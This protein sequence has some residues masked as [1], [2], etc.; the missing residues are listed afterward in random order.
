MT[1]LP[2]PD[3]FVYSL[4]Y[5]L[6][7]YND[8]HMDI[9]ERTKIAMTASRRIDL[10]ALRA[11]AMLLGIALHASL[12][13]FPFPWL[14]HDHQR[15][16]LLLLFLAI[17]HGF[18]MPL[19]FILSGYFTML[20]Y[21]RSGI[22]KLLDQRFKRIFLP[23]CVALLSII[24]LSQSFE[25]SKARTVKLEPD[26]EGII[27]GTD[28]ALKACVR[29]QDG[30]IWQDP[31]WK[32]SALAW[33][34]LLGKPESVK[35]LMD[36]GA[37]I[38][39]QDQ[40]GNTLLHFA[41]IFGRAQEAE[42]LIAGGADPLARNKLGMVPAHGL[43]T[44][45]TQMGEFA[46]QIG[47]N[48]IRMEEIR[49][50]RQRLSNLLPLDNTSVGIIDQLAI[51]SSQWQSS[52]SWRINL[53]SWS[54]HLF[55]SNVFF[56]LWFLWYLCWMVLLFAAL[57]R[58]SLLPSTRSRPRLVVASLF[59]QLVMGTFLTPGFG[60]DTSVGLLPKL[61]V[62]CY[63]A[64][65]FFYGCASFD[66]NSLE[67]TTALKRWK[68]LFVIAFIFFVIGLATKNNRI[69]ATIFQPAYAWTMS[70][71]LIGFFSYVASR[72]QWL[73]SSPIVSWL[74]DAS[75]WMYLVHVPLVIFLQIVVRRFT[76]PAELKFLMVMV[77]AT[78]VL[79]LSYRWCVRYTWIGW[80]LNGPRCF[81]KAGD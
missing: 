5:R 20:V 69:L 12:S 43:A 73:R 32:R 49:Q 11:F 72:S 35:V 70:L 50:G 39:E 64:C 62:I 18:R 52:E 79:L 42:L 81:K 3:G 27:A 78:L 10:D 29:N 8:L 9:A 53:G 67:H 61:H 24:P 31:Y 1:G 25:S 2:K 37:D 66:S 28:E 19:F 71:G 59:P 75:Y 14:V 15:S 46:Q 54:F 74:A 38:H 76:L 51:R 44:S 63:Y 26:V 6:I 47:L 36:A 58:F 23:L 68:L 80:F 40:L 60:P 57:E 33:A 55:D 17:V 13:Y 77:A 4:R 22:G 34:V 21:R 45:A 48:P 7:N 65:F 56:H 16:D 30:S 41:A